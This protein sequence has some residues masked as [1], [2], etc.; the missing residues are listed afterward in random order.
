MSAQTCEILAMHY[1]GEASEA[2]IDFSL[3]VSAKTLRG[4]DQRFK[5]SPA[6]MASY[7]RKIRQDL[8]AGEALFESSGL[9]EWKQ[10]GL[11]SE[12]DQMLLL[13]MD[14]VSAAKINKLPAEEVIQPNFLCCLVSFLQELCSYYEKEDWPWEYISWDAILTEKQID[15]DTGDETLRFYAL[16]PAITDFTLCRIPLELQIQGS[17]P[18]QIPYHFLSGP[19]QREQRA[20]YALAAFLYQ[21]FSG[22]WPF[23][24]SS[25]AD[26]QGTEAEEML[27][28]AMGSS[29]YLS[30]QLLEPRV[31]DRWATALA[32][33]LDPKLRS[34]SNSSSYGPDAHEMQHLDSWYKLFSRACRAENEQ[35][36]EEVRLYSPW[37]KPSQEE[38]ELLRKELETQRNKSE[39]QLSTRRFWRK[40]KS[41]IFVSTAIFIFLLSLVGPPIYRALSPPEHSGLRPIAVASLY[42]QAFDQL[43]SNELSIL[44]Y[45]P[46]P[47]LKSDQLL[48]SNLFINS[49]VRESY[50]FKNY[51]LPMEAWLAHFGLND[52]PGTA[53][54]RIP[55]EYIPYGISGLKLKEFSI[56]GSPDEAIV[57]A[58]YSYWLPGSFLYQGDMQPED[59][60]KP[61]NKAFQPYHRLFTEKL[62]LVYRR[63]RKAWFV[64]ST[65][66]DSRLIEHPI[67]SDEDFQALEKKYGPFRASLSA[68]K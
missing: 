33:V 5:Q 60:D 41:L 64:H 42:Y 65:Q 53:L 43:D 10:H 30:V 11:H 45:K 62:H 19:K 58:S 9:Q 27:R 32:A 22:H 51:V 12:Q 39:K 67:L 63:G 13:S 3:G 14:A 35:E 61:E 8:R 20:G 56:P 21:R 6:L 2:I 18:Y 54:P 49:K 50:E 23:S 25:S 4:Q 44:S 29:N 15:K 34:R 66:R 17:L 57:E 36:P 7:R 46:G 26:A 55:I 16:P 31:S 68:G 24:L 1:R 40:K 48:V 37:R 28:E 59:W 47:Q 38:Q 52:S